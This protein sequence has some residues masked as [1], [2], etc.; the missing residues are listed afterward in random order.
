MNLYSRASALLTTVALAA[1][2]GSNPVP[3]G[4]TSAIDAVQ[5]ADGAVGDAA[6]TPDGT[7][8]GG[9]ADSSADGVAA[10]GGS[11]AAGDD[12][13]AD[14]ADAVD[15]AADGATEPGDTAGPD[16]SDTA[17]NLAPTVQVLE[18]K[19][20][21]VFAK[22]SQV[23]FKFSASDDGSPADVYTLACALDG[24]SG[25]CSGIEAQVS[26]KAGAVEVSAQLALPADL[27]GQH[28]LVVEVT[29]AQGLAGTASV[30]VVVDSPPSTP[31]V[32]LEP[33]KPTA[34]DPIKVKLV[35]ASIDPDGGLVS[36]AYAWTLDGKPLAGET[37]QQPAGV[38]KKGQTIQVSVVAKD[39]L[40]SSAPA[41]A[42]VAVVNAPPTVASY[43]LAPA[44]PS[45]ASTLEAKE[46]QAATDADGDELT[47][48]YLWT[49]AG[50][51]LPGDSAKLVLPGLTLPSGAKVK[52]A[53]KVALAIEVSDGTAKIAA[54][55]TGS[56]AELSDFNPCGAGISPCHADATCTAGADF[57]AQCQ[58]KPGFGGDGK[59]C[60]D[61]DEC[62]LKTADCDAAATCSNKP[63]SYT[64]ACKPGYLGDGKACQDVDECQAGAATCAADATCVN[65]AGSFSCTCKPGFSGD[66]KTC[67]DVNECLTN[68]GGCSANATCKNSV[69]SFSCA[70]KAFWQGD[71]KTCTDID[72]CAKDNGGCGPSPLYGSPIY[73]CTN[74]AGAA[75]QCAGPFG[76][77][78]PA[79]TLVISELM[80][81]PATSTDDKGEWF[82]VTNALSAELDLGGLVIRSDGGMFVVP[83][84]VKIPAS[85]QL[86]FGQTKDL[87]VNGG[88]PV[89][90]AMTVTQTGL[91][92]QL[93]NSGTDE[94]VLE[95]NGK[96]IDS[97]VYDFSKGWPSA[98]GAALSLSADKLTADAND[99]PLS[100]CVAVASYGLG[101]KGT[102]GKVNPK[103]LT[104][105][106]KDGVDDA[107]DN[108]PLASNA[109][110]A[111][112]DGDKLGD[113]CDN[114]SAKANAN[115]ADADSDKVGDVCD[116]CPATS[117]A[118]QK[119]SNGNGVGD[120]CDT[121]A[122]CGN[123][124]VEVGETCDDGAK[125]A[126]DGCDA[127]CQLEAAAD[128]PKVGD[129]VITEMMIDPN[130][131][132]DDK[133]EYFEV[134]NVSTKSFDL[135][136]MVVQG[137][138]TSDK[139][140]VNKPLPIGAGKTIVFAVSLDTALNGNVVAQYQYSGSSFPLSNSAIDVIDLQWK[141]VS[142]DKVTFQWGTSPW[143]KLAGASYQL[144]KTKTSAALNDEPLNWCLSASAWS[145]VDKG[146]P[147]SDNA[148]CGLPVPS[149]WAP[150][151]G[152]LPWWRWF[153][154]WFGW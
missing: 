142:I 89:D 75:P 105:K 77:V 67:S 80:Y 36:Y 10:D 63:G 118:D 26:G 40:G 73:T 24:K 152:Q 146:S 130:A 15:G 136:G 115:Q 154:S 16:S 11:D 55:V 13:A 95:S 82:E 103:C 147:G 58:C 131:V 37:D 86:V 66:G 62:Q 102:P 83:A 6:G 93:S 145:G 22:G 32:E 70:C 46:V 4:G 87:L 60:S 90:V 53:D 97:V 143:T 28:T 8:D 127:N 47:V 42:S 109:N 100:W 140:T 138:S 7:S 74:Q 94:V 20:G 141:G 29:D 116:N 25:A 128:E 78:L 30:T 23:T 104:D 85:G 39:A 9:T 124:I 19:T 45:V 34:A 12:P 71:G 27:A 113:V 50:E 57:A 121:A 110:Q 21:A 125:V 107:I 98:T 117:N 91:A 132:N 135:N 44:A 61:L 144:S 120:A 49:V 3:A 38:A 76:P 14:A 81:N 101:D 64:C 99:S 84:G 149:N 96:I 52:A 119:D 72:E 59:S 123:K 151:A 111:D 33:A 133:G 79:G 1:A 122:V 112:A 129:L 56:P 114:C 41:T 17:A 106:D 2:C 43:A 134:K 92:V 54:T 18:P 51:L 48:T 153:K 150:G 139:F 108:C 68:N 148:E 35:Q 69:G 65:T 88:A 5:G 126:G 137:S 31:Q